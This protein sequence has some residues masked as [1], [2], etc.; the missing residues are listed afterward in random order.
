MN[1]TTWILIC[2]IFLLL[3]FRIFA[4][5]SCGGDDPCAGKST[6]DQVACYE[7]LTAACKNQRETLAS[8]ISYMNSQI[9]LTTLRISVTQ[10]KITTLTD[11]ISKLETEVVRLEGVLN[12]R[13]ALLM[14]R[15]PASY[16][17]SS[18]SQ[19]GALLFS[20]DFFDFMTRIKYLQSVQ[21]E[22]AAIV[23]QVKTTQN[24]YNDSKKN[25]EDKKNQLEEIKTEL[26]RQNIQL[27]QQKAEKDALLTATQGNESRYSQLLAA[28]RA[29]LS[30]INN[31]VSGLGGATILSNQTYHSDWGNYYNQR[32]SQWANHGIGSS[33]E[34]I[35]NV[36]CLVTSVA[37]V[38]SHYGKGASPAD[39]ASTLDLFV[40][41]TAYMYQGSRSVA[42]ATITRTSTS[43]GVI[44]GE[45][46][47]GHPV[48]VGV[49]NGPAHFVVLK[50]G[51]GGNYT[52]NDPFVENGHDIAF[53]SHYSMGAITEVDTVSVN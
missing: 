8:Q 12:D 23:F 13:L 48:I 30:A 10:N 40:P 16:K 43:T 25:R 6:T 28:A 35:A 27:A 7:N 36:G 47:A 2:F 41:G 20:R 44:D 45:L 5:S 31:F 46:A 4:Q 1:K 21:Q 14:K 38:M 52:M 42:G 9:K 32:D 3:P 24:S 53:T 34:S 19:F 11:E 49:Y 39:V 18:A 29:Q 17:R 26:N 15:I 33:S 50:S 37:M 51:S 22:D